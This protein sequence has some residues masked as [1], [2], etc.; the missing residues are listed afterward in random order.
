[1]KLFYLIGVSMLMLSGCR[2]SLE[3]PEPSAGVLALGQYL[4]IGDGYTAGLSNVKINDSLGNTGWYKEAQSYSF[5]SL[6]AAQF[7]L[8][9]DYPFSQPPLSSAGSGHLFVE[10]MSEP[11]CDFEESTPVIWFEA[12]DPSWDQVSVSAIPD[13]LGL[14]GLTIR[15]VNEPVYTNETPE[16]KLLGGNDQQTYRGLLAQARPGFFSMFLG[17]ENI[18]SFAISG[19]ENNVWLPRP[20]VAVH[21]GTLLETA[22]AVPGSYGV[23]ANLPDPTSFPYFTKIQNQFQN[24]ENCKESSLPIYITSQSGN[25]S[26]AKRTDRILLPAGSLLGTEFI[27]NGPFGLVSSNPVPSRWVMDEEDLFE[28]RSQ[29]AILNSVVDSLVNDINTSAGFQRLAIVDLNTSFEMLEEG[30]LEDGLTLSNEYLSGGIFSLDGLYLT[31]R[32]NAWLAN[33]FISTINQASAFGAKIPPLNIT[34]FPSIR[35]P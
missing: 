14:P 3:V 21:L 7:S 23:I 13:N 33:Q 20:E 26:T 9:T 10:S 17:L 32:G 1:M 15:S 34:S 5:P 16:W 27:G 35:Y 28:L 4:A 30:I 29:V 12:A 24:I 25:V 8:V 19:G 6:L 2:P 22:L 31:P 18:L 11:I